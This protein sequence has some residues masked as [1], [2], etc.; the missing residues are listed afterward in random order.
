MGGLLVSGSSSNYL[1]KLSFF[2]SRIR[3]LGSQPFR[4]LVEKELL[5]REAGR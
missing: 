2:G 4:Q 3:L 1:D 5:A